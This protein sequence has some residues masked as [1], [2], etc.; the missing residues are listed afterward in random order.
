MMVAAFPASLI[1]RL[2]P[3][4]LALLL[5]ACGTTIDESVT[6]PRTLTER[7]ATIRNEQLIG[8]WGVASYRE[9][10]DRKRVEAQ[11]RAQ[12]RLPYI[13]TKGPSDGVM[14]HLADDAK[15]YELR[16]KGGSDGK[17]YLGPESAPGEWQDREVI[18][19]TEKEMIMRFV[20]P[21][22]HGRYGTFIYVRCPG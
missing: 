5:A 8:K 9:E 14:M 10:K 17:T 11:A 7:P 16:I 3:A 15:L 1:R 13:I 4:A 12:C 22:V 2:A 19:I 21:E 6:T 18:S 20:D